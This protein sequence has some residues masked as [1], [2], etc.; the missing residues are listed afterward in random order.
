MI[1][2]V[3]L[4]QG[5][6]AGAAVGLEAVCI[7]RHEAR[8]R[9]EGPRCPH[10]RAHLDPVPQE[11]D[12]DQRGELPVEAHAGEP[13]DHGGRID[14]SRRDGD[15]DQRHHADL[16]IAHLLDQPFQEGPA[17]VEEHHRGQGKEHVAVAR[18]APPVPQPHPLLQHGRQGQDR[19]G[20]HQTDP[21]PALEVLD[22][23]GV[24][25]AVMTLVVMSLRV[26]LAMGR[27]LSGA[28]AMGVHL[29]RSVMGMGV[30]RVRHA[31]LLSTCSAGPA[32][33]AQ[34]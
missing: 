12:H 29:G 32:G 25:I 14:I 18:E 19:D 3:Q 22:H 11:H 28:F 30:D 6:I 24:V 20:Q 16:A 2:R 27:R 26:V 31:R 17:P 33:L 1:P 15:P 34:P 7:R 13:E 21:E 23:H 5:D 8:E 4:A 9:L 10:H